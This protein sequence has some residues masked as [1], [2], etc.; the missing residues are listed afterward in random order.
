[1]KFR[2]GKRG[3]EIDPEVYFRP[4]GEPRA[5]RKDQQ[6]CAQVK[7]AIAFALICD[8]DDPALEALEVEDVVPVQ[9]SRRLAV[10]LRCRDLG[11]LSY[12]ELVERVARWKPVARASVAGHI[13]RQRVPELELVVLVDEGGRA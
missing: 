11:G 8:C 9:G 4:S 10:T 3:R 1:M 12:V 7:R 6:L 2:N 13:H 5:N